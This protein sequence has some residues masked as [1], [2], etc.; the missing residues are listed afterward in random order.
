M[1][2]SRRI[3]YYLAPLLVCVAVFWRA[4]FIWFRIDDFAWLGLP[5]YAHDYGLMRA[6][7]DPMA[8]GTVRVVSERLPFLI[9]SAAFGLHAGP[10]RA[11]S[12]GTWFACLLLIQWIGWKLTG[13]RAAGLGAAVLWAVNSSLILPLSWASAYNQTLCAFIFLFAF[14]ARLR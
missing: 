3:A 5:Q 1:T 6:L 2:L 13:S 9:F 11:L 12:L 8:Q 4:P 7:F 10:F 14:Q